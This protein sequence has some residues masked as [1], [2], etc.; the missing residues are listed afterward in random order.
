M[1]LYFNGAF[2]E[3]GFSVDSFNLMFAGALLATIFWVSGYD[4]LT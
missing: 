3:R 2:I 4:N 1:V